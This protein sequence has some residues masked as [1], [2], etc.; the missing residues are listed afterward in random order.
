MHKLIV[1]PLLLILAASLVHAQNVTA[2]ISPDNPLLWRAEVFFEHVSAAIT[3]DDTEK[4]SKRMHSAEERAAE[5]EKML[6]FKKTEA[7]R[8]AKNA[9]NDEITALQEYFS[10]FEYKSPQN[11]LEAEYNLQEILHRYEEEI[12]AVTAT[13]AHAQ[14][15]DRDDSHKQIVQEFVE[16]ATTADFQSALN[17][18]KDATILKLRANGLTD[19]D[20]AALQISKTSSVDK[21]KVFTDTLLPE[22]FSNETNNSEQRVESGE[23]IEAVQQIADVQEQQQAQQQAKEQQIVSEPSVVENEQPHD[24]P[25]LII[26]DVSSKSKVK[27]DGTVTAEQQQ[28][29]N[30]LYSQLIAESTEAEVEIIVTQMDNGLWKIEKEID[31]TL[32]SLQDQQ[33]D[34]LLAS[35]SN[36]PSPL[37][38][39]VKYDPSYPETDAY[40]KESD[41]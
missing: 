7:A 33:V 2:G 32:T 10:A 15:D 30:L 29:V 5:M 38:I 9:F 26:T 21:L 28:A 4:I 8:T 25:H 22:I 6:S 37:H 14:L 17:A 1:V 41:V 12:T 31:G 36:A 11:E 18:K 40:I 34:A 27:V 35:L 13:L 23:S 3:Y 39:T 24:N 16:S 20:I 19:E